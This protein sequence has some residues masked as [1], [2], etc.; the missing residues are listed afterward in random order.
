M[1][2][3]D[4]RGI[5]A[6]GNDGWTWRSWSAKSQF[7]TKVKDNCSNTRDEEMEAESRLVLL[8]KVIHYM[9]LRPP[10]DGALGQALD[11]EAALRSAAIIRTVLRICA[12]SLH[13]R[14][15][16]R[17]SSSPMA[18]FRDAS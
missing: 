16:Q 2:F 18:E 10:F 15:R 9:V 4:V 14:V 11:G 3:V 8:S 6:R 17:Q 13:G 12:Q 5:S 1:F 7:G